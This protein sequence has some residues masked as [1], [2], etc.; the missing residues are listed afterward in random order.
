MLLVK[1]SCNYVSYVIDASMLRCFDAGNR[2]G[3]SDH[4]N[5]LRVALSLSSRRQNVGILCCIVMCL[6]VDT[7]RFGDAEDGRPRDAVLPR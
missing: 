7:C 3:H 1:E 5:G 6:Q 2:S 4:F